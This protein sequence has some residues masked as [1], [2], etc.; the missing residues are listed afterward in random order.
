[1]SLN[2]EQASLVDKAIAGIV[3]DKGLIL[4]IKDNPAV[5]FQPDQFQQDIVVAFAMSN[6]LNSW[7][8]YYIGKYLKKPTSE[9]T[10]NAYHSIEARRQEIQSRIFQK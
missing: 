6:I 8:A 10:S 3:N 2:A 7:Q 1:M 5:K 4:W 9:Q